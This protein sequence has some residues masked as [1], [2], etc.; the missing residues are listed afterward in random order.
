MTCKLY[1]IY[2]NH[3]STL[4]TLPIGVSLGFASVGLIQPDY[5]K[6]EKIVQNETMILKGNL[7]K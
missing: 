6:N 1:L 5:W 4:I 2:L 3:L 7:S